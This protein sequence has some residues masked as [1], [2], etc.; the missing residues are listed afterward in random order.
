MERVGGVGEREIEG[1]QAVVGQ[2]SHLMCETLLYMRPLSLLLQNVVYLLRINCQYLATIC[3][4]HTY[5]RTNTTW[6][7][8]AVSISNQSCGTSRLQWVLNL[9][10]NCS[11]R[12]HFILQ[13]SRIC[14]AAS[15]Q[16][17]WELWKTKSLASNKNCNK[18]NK[19]R[20]KNVFS[21]NFRTAKAKQ[22]VLNA[23]C[24]KEKEQSKQKHD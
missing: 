20:N 14:P 6:G 19:E 12:Q 22:K 23:R 11:K 16:S 8:V 13:Q 15:W 5:K 17:T 7:E 4:T 1:D 2:V 21:Q 24:S 18:T 10:C 3:H 9:K